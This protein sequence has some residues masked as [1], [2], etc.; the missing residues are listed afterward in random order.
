MISVLLDGFSLFNGGQKPEGPRAKKPALACEIT[1][2]E[3][4]FPSYR[5]QVH[6]PHPG[7]WH[8]LFGKW[9]IM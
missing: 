8:P 5:N 6:R 1:G 2:S 9:A 3:G 7:I 4:V